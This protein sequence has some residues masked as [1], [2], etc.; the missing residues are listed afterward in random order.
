MFIIGFSTCCIFLLVKAEL[1]ELF[2]SAKA[3]VG[4]IDVNKPTVRAEIIIL[5][6][7][8]FHSVSSSYYFHNNENNNNY[9][10]KI[11]KLFLIGRGLIICLNQIMFF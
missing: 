7:F 6:F 1:T 5:F 4:I 3:P 8:S 2:V 10:K 11:D 9:Q